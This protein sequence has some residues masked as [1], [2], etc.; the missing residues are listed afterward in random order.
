[1]RNYM[2][3]ARAG[4]PRAKVL[5]AHKSRRSRPGRAR[6]GRLQR[7]PCEPRGAR[8]ARA[9][10]R[11]AV[12]GGGVV[13]LL[14][15]GLR[16]LVLL[17]QGPGRAAALRHVPDAE[18]A[19]RLHAPRRHAGAGPRAHQRLRGAGRVPARRRAPG[20]G[21]RRRAQARVRA[22]EGEARSRGS[23]CAR[24]QTKSAAVSAA[25]RR[26]HL[27]LGGRAAR[28]PAC[29]RAPL[30]A[31]QGPHLSDT[32]AGGGRRAGAGRGA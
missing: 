6:P 20:G 29:A 10:A 14:T 30:S 11:C 23:V 17:A 2:R 26:D 25:Y 13:E 21:G 9:R 1:M 24:V 22:P 31:R 28:H 3:P 19:R 8:A 12:G 15:T 4:K 27:A 5:Y 18:L 7:Q 32:G 16:S